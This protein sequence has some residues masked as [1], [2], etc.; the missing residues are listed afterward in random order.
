VIDTRGTGDILAGIGLFARLA[1]DERAGLARL[2]QPR[3]LQAGQAIFLQGDAGNGLY[4]IQ[5]GR[6]KIIVTALTGKGLLI[7]TLGPGDFFGELALLDGEPRSANVVAQDTCRLLLL[8][9]VD[10]VP[11][12]EARPGVALRMLEVLSRRLRQTT[13]QVQDMAFSDVPTRLARVLLALA[14]THGVP[15]GDGVSINRRITQTELA[16]MIGATRE[17]ANKTL[18]AFERQGLIHRQRGIITLLAPELLRERG[19]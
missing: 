2:L 10:F 12:V 14:E 4:L 17:S 7:N 11:F 16:E 6:V 15:A 19:Y 13:L 9:R 8:R 5:E 18:K 1:A 3:V